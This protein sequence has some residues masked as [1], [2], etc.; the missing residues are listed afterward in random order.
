MKQYLWLTRQGQRNKI[1]KETTHRQSTML[2]TNTKRER[3]RKK[4]GYMPVQS[5]E[6]RKEQGYIP[7]QSRERRDFVQGSSK[8]DQKVLMYGS[9]WFEF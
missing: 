4:Q 7:V 3:G 2:L 6:R 5:R 8:K 1:Y 9:I